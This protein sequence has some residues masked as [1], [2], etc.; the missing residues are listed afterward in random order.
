M[1]ANNSQPFV[2]VTELD[3]CYFDIYI[4]Q[5]G[6]FIM[7]P[8]REAIPEIKQGVIYNGNIRY[9]GENLV[10]TVKLFRNPKD[11]KNI[12]YELIT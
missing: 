5:N 8:R 7:T 2:C 9:E 10:R 4:I 6:Q 1:G 11:S 3:K 12:S